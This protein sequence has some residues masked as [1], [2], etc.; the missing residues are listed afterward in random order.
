MNGSG[1][2]GSCC[3]VFN[4]NKSCPILDIKGEIVTNKNL[5]C[6][7]INNRV[8]ILLLDVNYVIYCLMIV[9]VMVIEDDDI[10]EIHENLFI[11]Y[12]R[13]EY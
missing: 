6:V 12:L 7:F 4:D 11:W 10:Q 1:K 2:N 3:V 9:Y 5:K 13:H 8:E